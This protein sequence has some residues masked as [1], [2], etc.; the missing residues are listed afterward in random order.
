MDNTTN[1][2]P[3]MADTAEA[4]VKEQKNAAAGLGKFRDVD[5]LL[6]AYNNLEA[7]F[8]RRSQRL[9]QL[10]KA[11]K[12]VQPPAQP[13][14]GENPPQPGLSH[15][16]LLAAALGDEEVKAQIIAEYLQTAAKNKSVPL[17]SGG[18]QVSARR[19]TPATIRE[20]GALAQQFLNKR[21]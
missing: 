16:Q 5:A 7:E 15:E 8:T 14:S 11:E 4:E 3:A 13:A 18:V 21:R 1:E 6:E 9:R 12:D 19:K 10:E 20:A 17:I 2:L